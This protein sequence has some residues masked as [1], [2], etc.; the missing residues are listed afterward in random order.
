MKYLFQKNNNNTI[1]NIIVIPNDVDDD[2]HIPKDI[3]NYTEFT[4]V[5]GFDLNFHTKDYALKYEDVGGV[6]TPRDS[7]DID[8]DTVAIKFNKR[9]KL[10]IFSDI[11]KDFEAEGKLTLISNLLN[12]YGAFTAYVESRD[13]NFAR[14][15]VDSIPTEEC[16]DADKIKIKGFLPS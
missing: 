14:L 16:S 15:I 12:N 2:R 1:T 6:P 11:R 10:Q 5:D 8:A 13:F 3:E 4:P 9:N 7:V